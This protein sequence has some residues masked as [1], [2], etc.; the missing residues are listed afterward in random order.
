MG[1]VTA[2]ENSHELPAGMNGDIDGKITQLDSACR[3]DAKTIDSAK[4]G[5]VGLFAGEI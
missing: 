3:L 5:A 1:A 4:H 2:V